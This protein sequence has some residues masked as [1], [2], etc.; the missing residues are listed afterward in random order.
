MKKILVAA[1]FAALG[2]TAMSATAGCMPGNGGTNEP[3]CNPNIAGNGSI[4]DQGPID[5]L[6]L[7]GSAQ[8]EE[9]PGRHVLGLTTGSTPDGCMLGNGGSDPICNPNVQ[10][11]GWP[12]RPGIAFVKAVEPLMAS[13]SAVPAPGCIPGNGG[14]N[15]SC[16]PT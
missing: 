10:D 3:I 12:V 7:G 16:T 14:G 11:E 9:I 6:T 4:E 13:K 8:D 2:T 15:P 5:D 1:L